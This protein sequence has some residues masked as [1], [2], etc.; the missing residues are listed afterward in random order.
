ML[1]AE[2]E[3]TRV[4]QNAIKKAASGVQAFIRDSV[5]TIVI[6]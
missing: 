4:A 3:A 1:V 5:A 2:A 6:G